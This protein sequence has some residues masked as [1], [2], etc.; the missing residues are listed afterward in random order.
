MKSVNIKIGPPFIMEMSLLKSDWSTDLQ[1]M[2]ECRDCFSFFQPSLGYI[3]LDAFERICC[4]RWLTG[5]QSLV[6]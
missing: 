1:V 4:E 6:S 5:T 2:C 3:G